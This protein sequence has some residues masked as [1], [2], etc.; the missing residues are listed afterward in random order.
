MTK[1]EIMEQFAP[2]K[3]ENQVEFDDLM[4]AINN[5]QSIENHPFLDRLRELVRKKRNQERIEK[6]S[7][8]RNETIRKERVRLHWGLPQRTKLRLTYDGWNV[9]HHKKACHRNLF[10]KHGYIVERGGDT[11]YYDEDTDRRPK[12]EANAH[13]YGLRVMPT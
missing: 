5:Q 10:R 4:H 3:C 8:T 1:K 7:A 12:M 2:K 6:A 9:T 11:V 13:L